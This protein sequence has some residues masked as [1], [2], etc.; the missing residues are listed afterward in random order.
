MK[1]WNVSDIESLISSMEFKDTGNI[2]QQMCDESEI[3]FHDVDIDEALLLIKLNCDK[4]NVIYWLVK[5]M[6]GSSIFSLNHFRQK[7]QL[8]NHQDFCLPGKL[9]IITFSELCTAQSK[10]DIG[11][12][13]GF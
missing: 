10:R 6:E 1:G 7:A 12:Q 13:K 3:K 5:R 8:S 4:I 2:V 11:K 9:L